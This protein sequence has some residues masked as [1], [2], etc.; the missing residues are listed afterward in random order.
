MDEGW[1][2][3][4]DAFVEVL[5]RLPPSSRRRFR[6]V[7]RHW[8]DVVDT[9][10]PEMQSRAVL[11]VST[12]HGGDTASAYA[13]ESLP[14]ACSTELWTASAVPRP[15]GTRTPWQ[16][17]C[18]YFDTV[19]VGTCNGLL[20]VCDNAKGGGAI[21]LIN[22]ATGETLA[23]P[24]VPHAVQ[25]A[26]RGEH[27]AIS[28][29]DEAY[30]FAY[31]PTTGRYKVVHVPCYFDKTGQFAAVQV[32]T[33]GE[34]SW[35][36]VPAPAGGATCRRDAG[37]VSVDG[38]TYWVTKDSARLVAFDLDDGEGAASTTVAL[39]VEAG[40]SLHL[41][42][43]RGRPAVVDCRDAGN[44]AVIEVWV[45]GDGG[46]RQGWRRLYRVQVHGVGQ[47]LA[48]PHFAH[49]K[50]VLTN[51][52]GAGGNTV[53]YGHKLQSDPRKAQCSEVRISERRTGPAVTSTKGY[54]VRTFAYVKTTEPLRE[55][56][57]DGRLKWTCEGEGPKG[58]IEEPLALIFQDSNL[59]STV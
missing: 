11:L 36:D 51:Q 5:L 9:R 52:W 26:L 19:V 48:R 34:A 28:R 40:R 53:M 25:W 32:F 35:R 31:H 27:M 15:P 46:D 4:T 6:L 37:L 12:V 16:S 58:D 38:A 50:Y 39:P 2:L 1:N 8:R 23:V 7:C 47:R 42:A 14:E 41:T 33:L 43:V 24:P 57:L 18:Y 49:G 17:R 55:Y 3:P 59:W 13:V 21:S 20:C 44:Q 29:W 30:S 22:P 45:L 10:T 56:S 54:R